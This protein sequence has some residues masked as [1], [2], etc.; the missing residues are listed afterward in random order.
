[1]MVL[2]MFALFA[3]APAVYAV[4]GVIETNSDV[5]LEESCKEDWVSW[6]SQ[7]SIFFARRLPPRRIA[8]CALPRDARYSHRLNTKRGRN[9]HA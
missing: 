5:T 1:M 7:C 6:E 2:F 9:V 3:F 4:D 8:K